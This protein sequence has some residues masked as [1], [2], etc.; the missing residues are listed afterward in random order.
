[1]VTAVASNISI[2][3]ISI[4]AFDL[5]KDTLKISDN[6]FPISS[7]SEVISDFF[8]KHIT[9]TREGKSKSCKFRDQDA[10]VK[11]KIDRYYN[12]DSDVSFIKLASE[13]T[14]NLFKIMSESSSNSSG[15]F[16]VLDILIDHEEWIFMIKLDPKDGVQIDLKGLTVKVLENVLP[17]SGDRVHKCALI[18][19]EKYQ[20]EELGLYVLDLQQKQGETAKFFLSDFLQAEELL[21]DGI[22]SRSAVKFAKE[23]FEK[24]VPPEEHQKMLSSI[25]REFSNGSRVELKKTFNNLLE[26]FTDSNA[27]DRELHIRNQ[28]QNFVDEYLQRHPDHNPSF[29]VA[30]NDSNAVF[31][32]KDNKIFF[33]YDKSLGKKVEF[34]EDEEHHIILISKDIGFSQLIK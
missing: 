31:K 7:S 26:D 13:L 10:S 23:K 24:I 12:D 16:F 3:R 34:A 22:I 25:D 11:I 6:L 28:S 29:T 15:T 32:D 18:K 33:R 17:D 1:M 19:K 30:R 20:N 4:N 5:E 9:D 27:I 8:S 21:N 2:K 14:T